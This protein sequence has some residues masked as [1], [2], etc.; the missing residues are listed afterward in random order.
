MQKK[1]VVLGGGTGSSVLLKGLKDYPV[2]ITSVVSVCDD[3][4]ST[5]RLRK[6]FNTIAVGDLRKV[7]VSMAETEPLVEELFNYRFDTTSDLDGHAV[8]NILLTAM[9]NIKGNASEC[10]ESL[11]KVLN[12]KGKILP[13]TE[14]YV[15]LMGK[16]SE[17]KIIE[18]EANI[19]KCPDKIIDVFYK[20]KPTINKA[21]IESLEEADAILLSMGSLFTSILPNL[22][23]EDIIE[24]I[25]KSKAK[26]I[27]VCNLM[28]QPGETEELKASD[29]VKFLNAHLGKKKINTVLVNNGFIDEKALK[30]YETKEQKGL[31]EVDSKELNRIVKK[32]ITND[33]VT[34]IDDVIRHNA[35][36]LSIDIM[37][38]IID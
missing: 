15:V 12:L 11:G 17:G 36:K 6:E 10:I 13:L 5:G 18:G 27:Y 20:E 8:G 4:R 33:Y 19:T 35:A 24:A 1:L 30:K 29:H 28:S 22:I 9:L 2:D 38:D 25:D 37:S 16:T 34:V 23:S 31:V 26:I 21:I 3:G 14:D 7:L 32:V